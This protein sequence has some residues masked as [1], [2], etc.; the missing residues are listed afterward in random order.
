MADQKLTELTTLAS[1][2]TDD[3]FYVVDDPAG[4]AASKKVA[5]SVFDAR[6][7]AN[8]AELT[9]LAGLT[10]AAD[11]LPY[12]TGSGTAALADLSSF[13]RTLLDDANAGAARTTLGLA[14][15]T[16]VQA[17]DADLSALAGLSSSG[18][19]ARTGAGTAAARTLTAPAA[20]I[21]VTDGDGVS[22][23]PTLVLANDLAG[24]EG[25][26]S[27]GLAVRSAS[28][29]WVQRTITAGAN[30]SVTN[31]NGVSGNPTIAA[32]PAGSD[33]HIQYNNGSAF[34]GESDL[35]WDD[36]N[37]FLLVKSGSGITD[38]RINSVG[39]SAVHTLGLDQ[40]VVTDAAFMKFRSS[41]NGN[42]L[43]LSNDDPSH[44]VSATRS[45]WL[46]IY[47]EDTSAAGGAITD[48]YYFIPFYSLTQVA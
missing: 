15:G 24:L 8:D 6:Y 27:T 3:I 42:G 5:V 1:L 40:A 9:A 14:I 7:Q 32:T 45:G 48:G 25:L 20:G 35:V 43:P 21:T 13:I 12:F 18:L 22:G 16:D 31:G 37:K 19:I 44:V 33:S 36:T 29:T 17:F 34:G 30:V 2:T 26:S 39:A 46:K 11:K 47:V 41:S 38:A 28:D 4:L 23:N 10:S